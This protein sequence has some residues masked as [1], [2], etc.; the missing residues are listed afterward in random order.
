MEEGALKAARCPPEQLL[1]MD[2]V[3]TMEANPEA[4]GSERG[5]LEANSEHVLEGC[6]FE[7][8]DAGPPTIGEDTGQ[9]R[10]V[11]TELG[12]ECGGRG[13]PLVPAKSGEACWVRSYQKT[14]LARS[15]SAFSLRASSTRR[16]AM[17]HAL[18]PF[19]A[20]DGTAHGRREADEDRRD[21]SAR[22]LLHGISSAFATT[23]R[24]DSANT[25]PQAHTCKRSIR[26][27]LCTGSYMHTGRV[28]RKAFTRARK[29]KCGQSNGKTSP[30]DPLQHTFAHMLV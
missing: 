12:F 24:G 27:K 20:G 7:G 29:W 1:E 10:G 26:H 5:P 11:G 28:R 13:P 30:T 18:P 14:G 4:G 2:E 23:G 17:A 21:E 19:K 9:L 15:I 3:T 25:A 6:R 22:H 16:Q 8:T